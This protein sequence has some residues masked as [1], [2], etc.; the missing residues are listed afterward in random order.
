MRKTKK[1]KIKKYFNLKCQQE[2][3]DYLFI[4]LIQHKNKAPLI[5]IK[6]AVKTG[7][8]SL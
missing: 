5:L 4:N 1:H 8:F 7:L 2:I 6:N 3:P